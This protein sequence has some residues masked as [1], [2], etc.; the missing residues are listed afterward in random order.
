MRH[1]SSGLAALLLSLCAAV[2]LSAQATT[3]NAPT[4]PGAVQP[5]VP[6]ANPPT[7]ERISPPDDARSSLCFAAEMPGLQPFIV[8]PGDTLD[9]LLLGDTAFTPAQI[10]SMNCLDSE[11]LPPGAAI[12]LP[13]D[14]AAIDPVGSP[15]PRSATDEGAPTLTVAPERADLL[16][17]DVLTIT[18]SAPPGAVIVYPCA[19]EQ[20]CTRPASPLNPQPGPGVTLDGFQSAGTYGF[21]VEWESL[22]GETATRFVPVTI[23]CA[24]TWLAAQ[25]TDRCPDAP[26]QIVFAVY[27]PFE[28]GLMIYRSDTDTITILYGTGVSETYTDVYVEG[29]PA[30]A[31]SAPPGLFTPTRGFGV[32]WAALGGADSGLG[33]A[34]APERGYDM[35]M[36]PAG[37]LSFTTYLSTPPAAEGSTPGSIIA[38]TEVAGQVLGY[39]AAVAG[40]TGR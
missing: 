9:L 15:L 29:M 10:A 18:W 4:P 19:T 20:D 23:T 37:R 5:A 27:Q 30:P 2:S 8:R 26:A 1:L 32:L 33:W 38:V 12:W 7:P 40:G 13:G 21:Q 35:Q 36:Q 6:F 24:Y 39:W 25:T 34:T 11:A 16:N 31:A 14:S 17:T 3:P 22:D 28:R